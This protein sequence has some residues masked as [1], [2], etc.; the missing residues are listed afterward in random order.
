MTRTPGLRAAALAIALLGFAAAARAADPVVSNVRFAQRTDGSRLVDVYYNLVD[1]DGNACAVTLL[2]SD[3]GGAD[4]VMPCS[5]CTGDVGPGI[6]P[7]P[8]RHIV[9]NFGLDNAGWEGDD[10][11]VRVVASDLGTLF[12]PHSPRLYAINDW[13]G[14]DWT[15]PGQFEKYA[16]ADLVILTANYLWGNPLNESLHVID[17]IKAIN[18]SCRVIGYV[19]GMTSMLVWEHSGAT[20]PFGQAWFDRTRPYWAS[21]TL[22]DTLMNWPGQPVVDITNPAC[23]SE[24]VRTI[25]EFQRNSNNKFDG[26]FWDYF[27]NLIW[28]APWVDPIVNGEPDFDRDG[29]AMASD[30]DE[31]TAFKAGEVSLI[32]AVRDSMGAGFIQVFNGQRAYV[33]SAFAALGD[34]MFYEAFPVVFFPGLEKVR[35]AMSPSFPYNLF[36]TVNWPRRG[37]GGPYNIL[38]STAHNSY[39]D[40]TGT[41]TQLSLGNQYRAIGLLAGTYAA[42]CSNDVWGYGWTNVDISLGPPLGPPVISGDHYTRDFRHG[43]IEL[44]METGIYPDPFDYTIEVNG[45]IVEQWARPYHFP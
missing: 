5:Q 17:R 45:R 15:V 25:V 10:Y 12:P 30:P 20:L 34:G 2:A 36:R 14:V 37:N 42:W 6:A 13:T 35:T 31:I 11:R 33:D 22:G 7:G 18:P 44:I 28:I 23:R 38:A 43:R 41:M 32:G 19:L 39:M 1:A 16:R 3:D 26:I 29:I 4:W 9:W 27:N 40:H 24:M 21:T 8:D